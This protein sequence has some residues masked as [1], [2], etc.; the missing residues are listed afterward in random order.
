MHFNIYRINVI[1]QYWIF[2]CYILDTINILKL[3]LANFTQHRDTLLISLLTV[4]CSPRIEW[5]PRCNTASNRTDATVEPNATYPAQISV[6]LP[7]WLTSDA[8]NF[9]FA[10][11]PLDLFT[12]FASAEAIS[13]EAISNKWRHSIHRVKIWWITII[14]NL[15]T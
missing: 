8:R 12:V 3:W 11:A 6:S 10:R 15:K 9:L 2:G 1:Y 13:S 4:R 14:L 5:F 7:A